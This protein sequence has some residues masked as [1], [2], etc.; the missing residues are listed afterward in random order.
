MPFAAKLNVLSDRI[1]D[2]TNP[3]ALR[4][5]RQLVRSRF[6]TALIML[7]MG[8]LL[9]I[10]ALAMNASSDSLN[11][12]LSL[13]RELVVALFMTIWFSSCVFIPIYSAVRFGAE[14]KENDL[15]LM[16][17]STISP[18]RIISGK[19]ACSTQMVVLVISAALPFLAL[20]Y[21]LRGVD[22]RLVFW[23][24]LALFVWVT[25]GTLFLMLYAG[26]PVSRVS[27]VLLGL[28]V[29]APL[30]LQMYLFGPLFFSFGVSRMSMVF[31]GP[32]TSFLEPLVGLG[33]SALLL[34]G[35][36]FVLNVALV[37][38]TTSNRA[39]PVRLYHSLALLVG[40]GVILIAHGIGWITDLDDFMVGYAFI[41]MWVS[42]VF[43][44]FG[45]GCADSR[46]HRVRSK[47]PKRF[48]L[49][50]LVF[51]FYAGRV[52][53]LVWGLLHMMSS[54]ALLYFLESSGAVSPS[55]SVASPASVCGLYLLC[56]GLTAILIQRKLFKKRIK[57]FQTPVIFLVLTV[58]LACLPLLWH[59]LTGTRL[60]STDL[61]MPLSMVD[62]DMSSHLIPHFMAGLIWLA[63]LIVL[64]I[65]WLMDG[66]RSFRPPVQALSGAFVRDETAA[67]ELDTPEREGDR[68]AKDD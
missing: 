53:A 18:W 31:M 64:S 4:E 17:I 10:C 11:A 36:F 5:L 34:I 61:W 25:V 47:I 23:G 48:G 26:L 38:P 49:R 60:G 45:T 57:S 16:Y 63:V 35:S 27:R 44:W 62:D 46:S 56:Y 19:L 22:I 7:L 55:L 12:Q 39:V 33:T 13:G 32:S 52:N 6:V 51:P 68:A 41:S 1:A 40:L 14:R 21:F 65:R 50:L 8:G 28:F 42:G 29:V 58:V 59:V 15:D 67:V 30:W 2:R 9:L 54:L 66:I 37:S 43:L 20:T 24:V 3:I